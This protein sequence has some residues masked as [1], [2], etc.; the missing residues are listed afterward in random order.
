MKIIPVLSLLCALSV[1]S[2]DEVKYNPGHYVALEVDANLAAFPYLNE[3]AI[4]GFNIRYTWA[5]LEPEENRYEFSALRRD[6]AIAAKHGKQLVAFLT[7]KTFSARSP[8]P[9]PS[10]MRPYAM[11]NSSGGITPKKWDVRVIEREIALAHALAKDFEA[12]PN[13]EGIA[14]QESAPSIPRAELEPA[15]YTPE[16]FR[17]CLIRLLVGSSEA[18]PRSRVFWYQNFVPM[19]MEYLREITVAVLPYRIV[20]GGP[21]ILPYRTGLKPS[22]DLYQEFQGKMKLSSSAQADSYRHHK[23][24]TDN[25]KKGPFHQGL[26][27]IHPDGYV[28]M[29]Q[30]FEFGRDRLHLNYIF[31]SYIQSRPKQFPGDPPAYVFEDALKVIRRSPLAGND[32]G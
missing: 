28:T 19:K 4:R 1:A 15:G 17:D 14:W 10:Y 30:I 23:D 26:R 5:D 16:L 9:L 27:P 11:K 20:L 29:Q 24:D 21:D 18:L 31:W 2:G 6:L 22:Y 3:P 25:S 7:D 13:F 8:H 32:G 12:Q